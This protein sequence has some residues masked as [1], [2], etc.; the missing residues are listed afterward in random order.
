MT[1]LHK[2]ISFKDIR[3]NTTSDSD[4]KSLA[5]TTVFLSC[6]TMENLRSMRDVYNCVTRVMNENVTPE[7]LDKEYNG[8]KEGIIAKE[9]E[10]LRIIGFNVEFEPPHKYLLNIARHLR[11]NKDEVRVAWA[12]LNDTYAS[13]E[14]ISAIS[15]HQSGAVSSRTVSGNN[16]S[17]IHIALVKPVIIASACLLLALEVCSEEGYGRPSINSAEYTRQHRIKGLPTHWWRQFGV[18][19]AELYKAASQILDLCIQSFD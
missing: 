9:H 1:Y 19:D 4:K 3:M 15:Q 7:Q 12:I 17:N 5:I 14:C 16:S 11:R 2:Y 18:E 8:A 10:L 13:S 6:K